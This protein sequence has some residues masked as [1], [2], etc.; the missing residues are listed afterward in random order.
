MST[1]AGHPWWGQYMTE[2][3]G[4]ACLGVLFAAWLARSR[5]L[6]WAAWL[7]IVEWF[8][9]NYVAVFLQFAPMHNTFSSVGLLFM[10]YASFVWTRHWIFMPLMAFGL[11]GLGFHLVQ[12]WELL[13]VFNYKANMNW[14]F[15]GKLVVVL[16]AAL[17]SAN[18]RKSGNVDGKFLD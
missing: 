14:L 12:S 17:V 7:L 3:F 11:A 2:A 1:A 13:S 16:I 18:T 8:L 10:A 9:K 15:F 4:C 5:A 6:E